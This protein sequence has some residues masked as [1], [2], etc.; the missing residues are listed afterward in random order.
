[1]K[2]HGQ[3]PALL[4]LPSSVLKELFIFLWMHVKCVFYVMWTISAQFLATPLFLEPRALTSARHALLTIKG[5]SEAA[6]FRMTSSRLL[7]DCTMNLW[8]LLFI[9]EVTPH[10]L[11]EGRFLSWPESILYIAC[12]ACVFWWRSNVVKPWSRESFKD[13]GVTDTHM[14]VFTWEL[15][16][17]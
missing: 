10:R 3:W 17:C 5:S 2:A 4:S 7:C 11:S 16:V 12:C 15:L 8:S 9:V 14:C 6:S 1:M 13:E